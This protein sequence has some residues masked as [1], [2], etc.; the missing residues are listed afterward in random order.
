MRGSRPLL[1]R[2]AASALVAF[3]IR[4]GGGGGGGRTRKGLSSC[5]MRRKE[6]RALPMKS[7]YALARLF[8]T[9]HWPFRYASLSLSLSRAAIGRHGGA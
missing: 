5:K 9:P 4:R 6:E 1:R 8:S 2:D 7:G 3:N